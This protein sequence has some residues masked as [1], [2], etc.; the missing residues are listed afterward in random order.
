MPT[1]QFLDNWPGISAS[2]ECRNYDGDGLRAKK[3]ENNATTYYLRSSVLGGQVVAELNGGAFARGYVY[4]GGQM[5]AIQNNNDSVNWVLQDPVTKSQRIT[6][7]SGNVTATV[8]L[9]PWGGETSRSS[10]SA[11]QPH[12]YTTYTRDTNGGDEA[13]FRGYQ[14]SW[15]RFAQP[16]PYDGSYDL[17]DPQSFNRY[18]YVQ[19]DPVNFIDP[20]GLTMENPGYIPPWQNGWNQTT[21]PTLSFLNGAMLD[22]VADYNW[23][24]QEETGGV[25]F[26]GF[27]LISFGQSPIRR[28]INNERKVIRCFE[29][30]RFSAAVSYATRGSR[31]HGVATFVAQS[32][33]I[34]PALSVAGDA[35]AMTAKAGRAGIGGTTKVEASGLNWLIRRTISGPLKGTLQAIG[36]KVITPVMAGAFAFT[37]GYNAVQGWACRLGLQR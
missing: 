1:R 29:G 32:A 19:N 10:N 8:D 9:D 14:L 15:N 28:F 30:N 16:D 20:S 5:V 7:S 2:A 31:L 36:G 25:P 4:L 13:M 17:N 26:D 34:L 23:F 24:T 21:N 18:A 27:P 11:F 35:A 37:T 6:D 12:R 33:E 3:T 22:F